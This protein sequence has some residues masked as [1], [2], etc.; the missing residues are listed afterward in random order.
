M[1]G[2]SALKPGLACPMLVKGRLQGCLDIID[3]SSY[4]MVSIQ[5]VAIFLGFQLCVK[6]Y[7]GRH[8]SFLFYEYLSKKLIF[9]ISPWDKYFFLTLEPP[10]D[11][12]IKSRPACMDLS[13]AFFH[14]TD[15]SY[16]RIGLKMVLYNNFVN[17]SV[18]SKIR[19]T[20]TFSLPY[21]TLKSMGVRSNGK[22]GVLI[23]N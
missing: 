8:S 18:K 1:I 21:E 6:L 13:S 12:K 10:S 23:Y 14:I 9:P 3:S 2:T 5:N 16:V 20:W 11:Y 19:Q 7:H 4:T 22:I 17:L 15:T